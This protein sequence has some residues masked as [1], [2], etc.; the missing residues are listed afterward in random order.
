[1]PSW[2]TTFIVRPRNLFFDQ[3]A[4]EKATALQLVDAFVTTYSRVRSQFWPDAPVP[5]TFRA[6]SIEGFNKKLG[7]NGTLLVR[8]LGRPGREIKSPP[9]D[10]EMAETIEELAASA[11]RK[12]KS[13]LI[14]INNQ[15][16]MRTVYPSMA[17]CTGNEQD[18]CDARRSRQRCGRDP[19]VGGDCV[20]GI[21]SGRERG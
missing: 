15:R 2:Q 5:A 8:W 21:T 9:V 11:D 20:D 6:H 10:A 4:H 19:R 12:P 17:V 3:K 7:E 1:V 18:R 13:E 14:A 16:V